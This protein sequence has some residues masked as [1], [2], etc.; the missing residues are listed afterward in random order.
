MITIELS[1][2]L[3]LFFVSNIEILLL[4]FQHS[5]V[6]ILVISHFLRLAFLN[7][8]TELS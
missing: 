6:D 8:N 7:I 3:V 2:F 4:R 1:I 5:I